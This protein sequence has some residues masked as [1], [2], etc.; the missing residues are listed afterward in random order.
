MVVESFSEQMKPKNNDTIT[1]CINL[2]KKKEAPY[3]D[4]LRDNDEKDA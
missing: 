2:P 1:L 4:L 3:L